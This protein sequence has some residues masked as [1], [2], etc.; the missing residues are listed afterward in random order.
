MG[1]R[2]I[3]RI[4]PK[5]YP[6][7]TSNFPI[8]NLGKFTRSEFVFCQFFCNHLSRTTVHLLL[9]N[10]IRQQH[11]AAA[12]CN[13]TNIPTL[14]C[15]DHFNCST[16][17]QHPAVARTLQRAAAPFTSTLTARVG[18]STYPPPCSTLKYHPLQ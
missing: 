14:K 7:Y 16:W 13:G 4:M 3:P 11:P 18:Y 15:T 1:F 9:L 10:K 17:K 6:N 12:S 8:L 5:L 2:I